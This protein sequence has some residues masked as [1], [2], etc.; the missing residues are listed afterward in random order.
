MALYVTNWSALDFV[1]EDSA[2]KLLGKKLPL[3]HFPLGSGA[4]YSMSDER[5]WVWR[6][7]IDAVVGHLK[8]KGFTLVK[9]RAGEFSEMQRRVSGP[10]R[11]LML[12]ANNLAYRIHVPPRIAVANLLVF[13]RE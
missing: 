8:A 1:V 9:R 11:T 10:L 6:F 7:N 13:E 4:W 2:R 3:E 12:H 5:L